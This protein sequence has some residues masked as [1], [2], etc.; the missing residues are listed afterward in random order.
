MKSTSLVYRG[1][2]GAAGEDGDADEDEDEDEEDEDEDQDDDEDQS[3]EDSQSESDWT[4]SA[5]SGPH[6]MQCKG[7]LSHAQGV[8][9]SANDI[10]PVCSCSQWLHQSPQ[11]KQQTKIAYRRD[12]Q[13]HDFHM[14][15]PA[16]SCAFD[17]C[18]NSDYADANKADANACQQQV[19]ASSIRYRTTCRHDVYPIM[20]SDSKQQNNV[21]DR[22]DMHMK[23]KRSG[24]PVWKDIPDFAIR[25]CIN[26]L[27][28]CL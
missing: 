5:Q 19:L 17:S 12:Q 15:S 20:P 10:R 24:G 4:S 9:S 8:A 18:I 7:D 25:L 27:G 26:V 14:V 1:W 2:G 28:S 11:S 3:S 23:Q 21:L 22:T 16:F 6:S 13:D